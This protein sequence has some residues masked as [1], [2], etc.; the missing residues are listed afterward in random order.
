MI[1]NRQC[2]YLVGMAIVW[3]ITAATNIAHAD[4]SGT[5]SLQSK[6]LWGG[7]L[8]DE[9]A[10][11]QASLKYTHD[12]GLFVGSWFSTVDVGSSDNNQIDLIAG[13]SSS[14]NRLKY[15]VGIISHNFTGSGPVDND[16]NAVRGYFSGALGAMRVFIKTPLTDASW[17]AKGDVYAGA[18]WVKELSGG[19]RVSTLAGFYYFADDALFD[20][21][22][23]SISKK[24]SFAF[25]NAT[26]SLIRQIQDT[27]LE[28][29]MHVGVGGERRDGSELDN[30]L[31]LSIKADFH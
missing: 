30:H 28:L 15:D 27:P 22:T 17:T 18:G 11:A 14:V 29:G 16:T 21:G 25:R 2:V 9:G 8:M 19:L 5:A 1:L 10:V 7:V 13:Y 20:N 24:Q 4:V 3:L 26:F 31:W 23:L 12:T 6:Y